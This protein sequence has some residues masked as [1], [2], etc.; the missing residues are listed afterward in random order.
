VL[1][2]LAVAACS[3]GGPKGWLIPEAGATTGDDDGGISITVEPP[4]D[5]DGSGDLDAAVAPDPDD[6]SDAALF[7]GSDASP[8]TTPL[9]PG[10][11]VITELMIASLSGAGDHAEWLEV[12]STR[13]CAIDL[14]GVRGDCPVGA[15]VATFAF[16]SDVWIPPRGTFVVADSTDPVIDHGVPG[17]V[18]AWDGSLG[19]VLRNQGATITVRYGGAILDSV[20][21]PKLEIVTGASLAFPTS[22]S[23]S[24]RGDWTKWRTSVA[25]WFPGFR[26]T[27]NAPNVDVACPS[28]RL[29]SRGSGRGLRAAARSRRASPSRS[30]RGRLR[31]R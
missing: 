30:P 7:D 20:T 9:A 1:V 14:Q 24:M 26:G 19:D 17:V 16:T 4:G 28:S 8:C 25:S 11:L 6:A 13:A 10:D 23:A 3:G 29:A 27:P 2:V 18:V 5:D 22:C 21:Y 15:K 12:T 31:C